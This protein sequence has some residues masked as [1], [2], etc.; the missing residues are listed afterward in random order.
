MDPFDGPLEPQSQVSSCSFSGIVFL[1][2]DAPPTQWLILSF[3]LV[4]LLIGSV[5]ARA[6]AKRTPGERE[7][8]SYDNWGRG[9][10]S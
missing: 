1:V 5:V 8:P 4:P 2:G 6:A 7:R 10:K 3:V 9:S